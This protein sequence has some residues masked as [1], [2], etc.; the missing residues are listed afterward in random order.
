M[1]GF[2]AFGLIAIVAEP[3]GVATLRDVSMAATLAD[4][5]DGFSATA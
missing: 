4:D 2:T 1:F 3:G 5:D